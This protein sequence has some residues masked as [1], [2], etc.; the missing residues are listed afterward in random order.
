MPDPKNILELLLHLILTKRL[1]NA[2]LRIKDPMQQV[3]RTYLMQRHLVLELTT[4]RLHRKEIT[5]Q[6]L[7]K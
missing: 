2:K 3:K 5:Q 1:A 7:M 6:V 4:K